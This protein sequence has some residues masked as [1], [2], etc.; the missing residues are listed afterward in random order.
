MI[1][2]TVFRINDT[3]VVDEDVQP[4]V[5][6]A[7]R[8]CGRRDGCVVDQVDRNELCLQSLR[9]KISDRRLAACRIASADDDEDAGLC[10]LA[11]DFQP[12]T[13]VGAGDERDAVGVC[14]D[15]S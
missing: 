11:G 10:K 1:R 8:L 7:Y 14:H 2:R 15:R 6:G 5:F 9:G 12:D 4:A 3:S 13:L